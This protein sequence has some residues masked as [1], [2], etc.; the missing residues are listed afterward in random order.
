MHTNTEDSHVTHHINPDDGVKK[1][2]EMLNFNY[3]LTWLIAQEDLTAFTYCV[4]LYYKHSKCKSTILLRRKSEES[5][6]TLS[7]V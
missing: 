3:I 6:M 1:N 4:L 2:S 7:E 5:D